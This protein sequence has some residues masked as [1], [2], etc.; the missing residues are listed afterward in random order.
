LASYEDNCDLFLFDTKS[1]QYGGTG[2]SFDWQLLN[3]YEGKTPFL[4][5]GGIGLKNIEEALN[6]T[7]SQ[8]AGFDLN[9]QLEDEPGIKNIT[10]TKKIIQII[11]NH[12]RN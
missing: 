2:K 7:H 5:S 10:Q 8:L 1:T 6:L 3:E 9:S 11:R 4:L 12:E